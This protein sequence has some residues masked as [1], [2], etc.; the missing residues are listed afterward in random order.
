MY[1]LVNLFV[2]LSTLWDAQELAPPGNLLTPLSEGAPLWLTTTVT[3][4]MVFVVNTQKFL[5]IPVNFWWCQ[6]KFGEVSDI[7][8]QPNDNFQVA[9]IPVSVSTFLT[10]SRTRMRNQVSFS[11][12]GVLVPQLSMN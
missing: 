8:F 6:E 3:G 12:V 2:K 10:K 1:L 7:L 4:H 9:G 11:E 5:F